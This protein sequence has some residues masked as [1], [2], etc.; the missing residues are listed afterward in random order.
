MRNAGLG[1]WEITE[2]VEE[3]LG[4]VK[5]SDEEQVFYR[6]LKSQM[7]RRQW[8]SYR[9]I[10]PQLIDPQAVSGIGYDDQGKP[11]LENA[12][13]HVSAT[14]SGKFSALIFSKTKR[15]G[16]D[17]EIIHPRIIKLTH[18]FLNPEELEYR[19]A[20]HALESL[21][22]IWGAKEAL[23]KLHGGCGLVFSQHIHINPFV[24][25]GNGQITGRVNRGDET[26]TYTL[27]YESLEDYILVYTVEP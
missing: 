17:I 1:V 6:G 4:Q 8:L 22:V 19:F 10:L 20:S 23:Y 15:V 27:F 11:G 7:R 21:Y 9:L 13:G 26:L 3:L 14:H 16:V 12:A 18:K 25:T 24:F 5:L 2:P